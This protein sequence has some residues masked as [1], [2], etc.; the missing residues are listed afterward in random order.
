M[1]LCQKCASLAFSN[2]YDFAELVGRATQG[3]GVRIPWEELI[4]TQDQLFDKLH[5]EDLAWMLGIWPWQKTCRLKWHR[6]KW[7]VLKWLD[8]FVTAF[9]V[10][11]EKKNEMKDMGLFA[12]HIYYFTFYRV[13]NLEK[14]ENCLDTRFVWDQ[15]FY[16]SWVRFYF[17]EALNFNAVQYILPTTITAS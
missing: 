15:F 4:T 13:Q 8:R 11:T 17:W 12:F 7:A 10:V 3:R 5:L 6:W 2:F 9:Y 1:I 14:E 16:Q